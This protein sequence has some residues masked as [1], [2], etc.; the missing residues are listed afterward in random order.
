MTL[1]GGGGEIRLK[2]EKDVGAGRARASKCETYDKALMAGK[3]NKLYL[4][5]SK[6]HSPFRRETAECSMAL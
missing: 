1:F 2:M 6:E 5:E 3:R 4:I